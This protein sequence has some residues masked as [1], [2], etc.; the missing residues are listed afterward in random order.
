MTTGITHQ[1]TVSVPADSSAQTN[2][3]KHA[4][5]ANCKSSKAAFYTT[6]FAGATHYAFARAG[7]RPSRRNKILRYEYKTRA[8]TELNKEIQALKGLASEELLMCIITLAAHGDGE[9]LEPP[10][11][12]ML[13]S[14]SPLSIAQDFLY[15]TRMNFETA[16][17]SAVE[18]LVDARGGLQTIKT[19]G[20]A[21]AIAL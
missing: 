14:A 17:L 7:R 18:K 15:Y 20:L 13:A 10:S 3:I 11:L 19:P 2:N 1:W 16:H 6:V 21:N 8:I 12:E 5:L 9:N 4:V